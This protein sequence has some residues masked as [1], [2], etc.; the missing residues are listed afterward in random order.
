MI[1]KAAAAFSLVVLCAATAVASAA[2]SVAFCA[3]AMATSLTV[4]MALIRSAST[5]VEVPLTP[6][7]AAVVRK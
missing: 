2:S 7:P 1:F 3:A 4:L 5:M 6:K